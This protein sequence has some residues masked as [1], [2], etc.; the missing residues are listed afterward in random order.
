MSGAPDKSLAAALE[1]LKQ[2]ERAASADAGGDERRPRGEDDGRGSAG[3]ASLR[4]AAR[5]AGRLASAAFGA[6]RRPFERWA[7]ES[8]AA[9]RLQPVAGRLQSLT[10]RVWRFYAWCY[11]R[12]AYVATEGGLRRLSPRR[13]AAVTAALAVL[14]LATPI[15]LLRYVVPAAAHTLYD[16][17]ML[18]T[19]KEDRLFLGRAEPIRADEGVYQV[20]GCRDIAACDG[21]DNT[22]VFRLRDN[23]ILD[24]G[25]WATRFE[26]YD[27]AEIA[28]AMVGEL[29]ECTIRY[30]GRRVKPLGWYPNIVSASCAPV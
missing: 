11:D 28:G 29:N 15:V 7:A 21:G 23:I 30:Y 5:R 8:P 26:P 9:R 27:P 17:V 1:A 3:E 2:A 22:T 6:L 18:V 20:H 24:I 4:S 10:R 25:R 12:F 13:A 19:M 14:T 16:A